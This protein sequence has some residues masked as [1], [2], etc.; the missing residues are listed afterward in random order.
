MQSKISPPEEAW[1]GIKPSVSYFRIFGCIGYVHVPDQKRS[2]LDDKSIKCVLLV[3]SEES[4]AYKLYDPIK[5]KIHIS[6][7][8]KFQEDAAWRWGEAKT[9]IMLDTDELNRQEESCQAAEEIIQKSSNDIAAAPNSTQNVSDSSVLGASG[10]PAEGRIRRPPAWMR[11]YV[12][13]DDLTEE[14]AMNFALFVGADPVTYNQ[15]SKSQHWRDAMDA[16][17]QAI[18]RNDTWELVDPPPNC[19][20]V[21]VK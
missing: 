6:R 21:G 1:S 18:Q 4:K 9:S 19:K 3:V 20:V 8:V 2:K 7:D 5:K 15:A 16:E 12:T 14:D 17:I 11:D 13:G 10:T